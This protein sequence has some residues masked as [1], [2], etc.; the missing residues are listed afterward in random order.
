IYN[1]YRPALLA[2]H[3]PV[4]LAEFG[5]TGYGG[6]AAGWLGHA[7]PVI[8]KQ[9]TEIKSL[10]FFNSGNDKNWI[11]AWR[12]SPATAT[13]DWTIKQPGLLVQ[14]L[15]ELEG[16]AVTLPATAHS[17]GNAIAHPSMLKGAPGSF[18]LL[19]DGRPFYVKGIVYNP[20]QDWRDGNHPLTIRQLTKDFAAIKQTGCNTI[21]RY[22]PSVYDRNILKMA[23]AADLKVIYGFWFDPKVDYYKNTR[24]VE[25]YLQEVRE[26]V[27]QFNNSPAILAWCI[28][29]QTAGALQN[30][31]AR[32]YLGLVQKAYIQMTERMAQIIHGLDTARPVITALEQS[33][34]LPA[35]LLAYRDNA[36]SVDIIGINASC[37]QT[38]GEVQP[39]MQAFDS[40]RP[41]LLTSFGPGG[42]W[43][44]RYTS[45]T[46][47][48]EED[49]DQQKANGY[50]TGWKEA[51]AKNK[52]Y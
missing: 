9:Y 19:A 42:Y 29:D 12:P 49:N 17:A 8:H 21:R 23:Q 47:Q 2:L 37:E 14:P 3:K 32:P 20:G 30:Y 18:T 10:V 36:P 16:A 52:G 40:S 7:L 38:M 4:M 46:S 22:Q 24:Q 31:Y 34:Q 13:I 11:T 26:K 35:T 48:P 44:S 27:A 15:Q 5:A 51:I 45:N 39:L 1:P 43:D 6:D 33:W 25:K 41:Y 50:A 28:G